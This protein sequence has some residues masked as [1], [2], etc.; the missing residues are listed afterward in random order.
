MREREKKSVLDARIEDSRPVGRRLKGGGQECGLGL[1][2][3]DL[4]DL[5]GLLKIYGSVFGQRP[6]R[7]AWPAERQCSGTP[8][9]PRAI[10]HPIFYQ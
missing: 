6:L 8:N 5:K 2:S 7:T 1:T 4:V 9:K 3:Q 10:F